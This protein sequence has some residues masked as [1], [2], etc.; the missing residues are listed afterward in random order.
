MVN[1]IKP[2]TIE[3]VQKEFGDIQPIKVFDADGI[4]A[5]LSGFTAAKFKIIS[6]K[7]RTEL[8]DATSVAINLVDKSVDWTM[9]SGEQDIPDTE[10]G[11][12][13]IGIVILTAAGKERRI[14]PDLIVKVFKAKDIVIP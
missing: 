8:L 14:H 7:D 9:V 5:D 12:D 11:D 3:F 1:L 10:A 6:S 2:D 4:A 13:H